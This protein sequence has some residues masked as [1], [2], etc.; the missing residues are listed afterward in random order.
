[1]DF[2]A[3][4]FRSKDRLRPQ[5][6]PPL[7]FTRQLTEREKPR[8]GGHE[9]SE[10]KKRDPRAKQQRRTCAPRLAG[11]AL[12]ACLAV[13]AL[14]VLSACASVKVKLGMRVYLDKIPLAS[15]KASLPQGPGIAPGEKL[16][17]VVTFT[18]A[19]GDVLV[20]EGQGKGKVMWKDL[21]VTASV[22]TFNQKGVL[23]LPRDPRVS[24]GKVPHVTITVPSHPDLHAELDIPL[25]YDYKFVAKFSGSR[26]ASG[27]SG[28]DGTDG[29]SGTMGSSDPNNPSPGGDGSNG[30]NGSDGRDGDPGGD[31]PPVDVRV[32]LKFEN[33]PVL[34]ISATAAGHRKLYLVDPQGGTLTVAAEGGPGG[35]GGKGG[36]G[37]R[38]GSGG[39]GIP[40]GTNGLNGAD[41]R[42]GFDGPLG[43]SGQI[44]VTYD[45]ETKQYLSAIHLLTK[46]GP[47]P[48]FKE[49]PVDPLW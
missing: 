47:V 20:T 30:T 28:L 21:A 5:M 4:D 23:S 1:V 48:V 46:G 45:P 17:L 11:G 19:N 7:L 6:Q 40:S 3:G 15:I 35:S 42:D 49:E 10:D 14:L 12:A 26:G 25:S 16:P 41:G 36:R 29:A 27:I 22:V 39:A 33:R 31:G 13:A 8:I 2:F 44:T 18:E 37:G 24:E 38:G 34:Q 32:A 9:V 43:K